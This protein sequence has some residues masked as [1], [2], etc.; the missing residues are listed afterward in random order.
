MSVCVLCL[1]REHLTLSFSFKIENQIEKKLH[2]S[3]DNS[4]HMFDLEN[5]GVLEKIKP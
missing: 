2:A 3:F 4:D 5:I 1:Y